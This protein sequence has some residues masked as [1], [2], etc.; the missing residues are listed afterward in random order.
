MSSAAQELF[1][2]LASFKNPDSGGK[3]SEQRL[4]DYCNLVLGSVERLH[5]DFKEKKDR[6]H[7]LLEDNDKKNLAKAV[8]GFANSAGGVLIWGIKD[9]TMSPKPITDVSDFVSSMLALAP[10]V[11]DP[12]ARGIDGNWIPSDSS[13]NNE[14]FGLILIPESDLPP[15]RVTL[16]HRDIQSHYYIRSGSSF[17]VA[18]HTQL[19]D[20][21]G[22]RPQP[23][24]DLTTRI[25]QSSRNIGEVW[26]LI[27]ILGIENTGRGPARSPLLSVKFS[28]YALWEYGIDGNHNYGLE[29]QVVAKDS[30]WRHYGSSSTVV[31]HSGMTRDVT[32]VHVPCAEIIRGHTKVQDLV[33]EYQIAAEGIQPAI[34]RKVVTA[35]TLEAE[36]VRKV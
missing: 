12:T 8:S 4:L 26:N 35:S 21:F 32:A 34:G 19:E 25:I 3:T 13:V 14:G 36:A 18:T 11:S 33:I 16:A 2:K 23:K 6:R 7:A 27:V 9:Q 31:I 1:D 10:L 30:T 5:I 28:P 17:V 22:R 29:K 24:L 20:M 15:H